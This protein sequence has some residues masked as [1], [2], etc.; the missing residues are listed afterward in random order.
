MRIAASDICDHLD[1]MFD[2]CSCESLFLI[3]VR[4]G[5]RL[6]LGLK[7]DLMEYNKYI[8]SCNLEEFSPFLRNIYFFILSFENL[9]SS[10][11]M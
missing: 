1:N 11:E 6:G 10:T 3:A 5:L 7:N 8:N 9:Q 2:F 4:L